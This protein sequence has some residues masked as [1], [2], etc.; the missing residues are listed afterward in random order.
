MST[1]IDVD[2]HFL[3]DNIRGDE[4]K[5]TG[6]TGGETTHCTAVGLVDT[7]WKQTANHFERA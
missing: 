1:Y 4:I 6:E 5:L 3:S 7:A 2:L